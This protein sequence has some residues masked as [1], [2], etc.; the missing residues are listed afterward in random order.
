MNDEAP[1]TPAAERVRGSSFYAAMRIMPRVEREAMYEIYAF[2]RNVDDVADGGDP[3]ET[4][5]AELARWREDIAALYA[6]KP[7]ARVF[8]LARPIA[9]FGLKRED[10]L[11]IIDGMEMDA[12]ED[13]R[14]PDITKLDLYCDR[15]ASAVGRLSIRVFGM[16]PA[17]GSELAHHLGRALQLTNIL[18]DLDED[19]RAGRLYLPRQ[20]LLAAG[21][22]STAPAE[23]LAHPRLAH[24]CEPVVARARSHFTE[25]QAIMVKAPRRTVRTPRIMYEAYRL[26]LEGLVRRGWEPPRQRVRIG[27]L[28][29]LGILL[30]AGL[31]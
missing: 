4:R 22:S 26:I 9:R 21:I 19:A 14:A 20:A 10:F 13:I 23:V 24:A 8:G 3:A 30:Q 25:A 12:V 27:K 2:C 17:E 28:R 18:R 11:S 7:P 5:L 1:L 6:G 15:V 31:F 29:L 16:P